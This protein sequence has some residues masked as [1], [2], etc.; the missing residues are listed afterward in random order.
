MYHMT[1]E[2]SWRTADPRG[3]LGMLPDYLVRWARG[4]ES[5]PATRAVVP[6]VSDLP[7]ALITQASHIA[8]GQATGSLASSM[9]LSVVTDGRTRSSSPDRMRASLYLG[10][11]LPA[12]TS[13]H[14]WPGR[15][16]AANKYATPTVET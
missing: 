15:N 3:L 13:I 12:K 9:P 10:H 8:L 2:A 1:L 14:G 6:P 16:G 7:T 5:A 11:W 4:L